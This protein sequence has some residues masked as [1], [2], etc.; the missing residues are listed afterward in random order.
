M[1]DCALF[2]KDNAALL[3]QAGDDSQNGHDF[4]LSRNGHGAGF[5]DRGYGEIGD[6]LQDI[7]RSWSDMGVYKDSIKGKT[8]YVGY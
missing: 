5:F 1:A 8:I 6:K 4:C 2:Q 7:C 3:C